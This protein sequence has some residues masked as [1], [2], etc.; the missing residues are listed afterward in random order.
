MNL[1]AAALGWV[2]PGLGHILIGH[3]GRGVILAVTIGSLWMGGLLIGGITVIDRQ[4]HPAWFIGQMFLAPSL[5]VNRY[6]Q[7]LRDR[8]HRDVGTRADVSPGYEPA[9]GKPEEQGTL[10]TSLA[11]LLNLLV[12]IDVLYR[13]PMTTRDNLADTFEP[14]PDPE[15]VAE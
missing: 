15:A 10:Y 13:D 3:V 4:H 1:A 12:V 2:L 11:G 6:H 9:F 7:H 14:A 8:Y 5:V